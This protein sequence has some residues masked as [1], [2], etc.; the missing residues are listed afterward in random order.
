MINKEDFEQALK[1][2][3]CHEVQLVDAR[4]EIIRAYVEQ[5]ELVVLRYLNEIEEE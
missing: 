3:A 2:L 1:S 5:L 4:L